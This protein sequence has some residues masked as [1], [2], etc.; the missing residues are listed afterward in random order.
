MQPHM[1]WSE[2]HPQAQTIDEQCQ[3][4]R[5]PS[6]RQFGGHA[7]RTCISRWRF[8]PFPLPDWPI[9]VSICAGIAGAPCTPYELQ[10][11]CSNACTDVHGHAGQVLMMH[12]AKHVAEMY[13]MAATAHMQQGA[14]HHR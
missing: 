5:V 2:S 12:A 8:L 14:L 3:H 1:A 13:T 10:H 11:A 6:R 9:Y 4:M 7:R